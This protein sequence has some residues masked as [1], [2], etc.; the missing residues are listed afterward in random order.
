MFS[1]SR[2][3]TE[4]AIEIDKLDVITF[5]TLHGIDLFRTFDR[6]GLVDG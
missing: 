5:A 3:S 1:A 4:T 6:V 2:N